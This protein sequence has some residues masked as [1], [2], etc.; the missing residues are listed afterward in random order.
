MFC[1]NCGAKNPA[2][3]R[4]C[5]QCGAHL[6]KSINDPIET[7]DPDQNN[8]L[9]SDTLNSTPEDM[10]MKQKIQLCTV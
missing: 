9:E 8:D 7:E 1:P 5:N 4:F 6:T 3:A 10:M 2:D